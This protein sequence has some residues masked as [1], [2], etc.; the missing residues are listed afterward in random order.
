[1]ES[2]QERKKEKQMDELMFN[3]IWNEHSDA[4]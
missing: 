3:V 4:S 2:K 1:M